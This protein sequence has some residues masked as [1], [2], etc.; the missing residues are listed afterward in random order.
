MSDASDLHTGLPT[1]LEAVLQSNRAA[2]AVLLI[3]PLVSWTWIVVM[4]RDMYG[5]MTGASAWMMTGTWDAPHLLLLW[6]MC[7]PAHV[8]VAPKIPDKPMAY[9]I[10]GRVH[11]GTRAR[12]LLRRLLLGVDAPAVCGG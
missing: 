5:P 10:T 11:H 12:C 9:G 2:G 4:A 8:S 3:L 1:T 7:V 6:A